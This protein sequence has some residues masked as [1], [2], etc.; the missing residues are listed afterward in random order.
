MDNNN[1]KALTYEETD[2]VSSHYILGKLFDL[3]I[4]G[5]NKGRPYISCVF[6]AI[7]DEPELLINKEDYFLNADVGESYYRTTHILLINEMDEYIEGLDSDSASFDEIMNRLN[8]YFADKMILFKPD[9]I[10]SQEYNLSFK[11]ILINETNGIKILDIPNNDSS[12]FVIPS[13]SQKDYDNLLKQKTISLSNWNIDVFGLPMYLAFDN[14]II[15]AD[16]KKVDTYDC[17]LNNIDSYTEFEIDVEYLK[18]QKSLI[19]IDDASY[20]FLEKSSINTF[21]KVEKEIKVTSN[22]KSI[23]SIIDLDEIIENYVETSTLSQENIT[24]QQENKIIHQFYNYTKQ[25]NLYYYLDDIYNFH[26]CLKTRLLTILAGLPGTGKTRLPL[27]YAH[28]FNMNEKDNTLL[29]VPISPSLSEPS[30][31]LGFYNPTSSMYIPS[32]NGLTYFLANAMKHKDRMHMVIFDEMNLSQIEYY[33]ATFLSVLERDEEERNISLYDKNLECKNKDI[34][35][36]SIN[37]GSNVLFVGTINIDETTKE[38]SDRLLDRSFVISLK[39]T[40]FKTYNG[41]LL[42]VTDLEKVKTI[43]NDEN[44]LISLLPMRDLKDFNYIKSLDAELRSFLDKFNK[45]DSSILASFRTSKNIALYLDNS[46]IDDTNK[47]DGFSK[48]KAIDYALKQTIIKKIKGP[49]EDLHA[50]LGD[51]NT[52]FNGSQLYKLLDEY[53]TLSSFELCK[54]ELEEKAKE[55]NRYS[56]VR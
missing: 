32:E 4:A 12:Y 47:N 1:I 33:F 26:A 43:P 39:R 21:V 8:E 42:A 22:D 30:D 49:E 44:G 3:K 27:E 11:Q 2:S 53:S 25:K 6:Q 20:F 10:Y 31:L 18:K 16:L 51:E 7:S 35:P 55:M 54:N 45:L 13:L 52:P 34:F 41:E 46:L 40:D 9:F 24:L 23:K 15:L 14:K 38:L 50:F 28:F 29:F 36:P 5:V 17:Q 56:Y 48:S 19:Y 37:I